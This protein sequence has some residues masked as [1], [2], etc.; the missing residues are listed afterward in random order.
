MTSMKTKT[1]AKA[2]IRSKGK[3]RSLRLR[4]AL[5]DFGRDDEVFIVRQKR[6]CAAWAKFNLNFAIGSV[7]AHYAFS[8]FGEFLHF[9][10]VVAGDD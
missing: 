3:S 2:K 10:G 9:G 7:N 5:R 6:L 4:H 1:K 8:Y